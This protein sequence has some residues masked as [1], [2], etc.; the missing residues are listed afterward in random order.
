MSALAVWFTCLT[1]CLNEASEWKSLHEGE[2]DRTFRTCEGV[3]SEAVHAAS[4]GVEV[5]R[6]G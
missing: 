5:E 3:S 4:S 1:N 6:L 2:T